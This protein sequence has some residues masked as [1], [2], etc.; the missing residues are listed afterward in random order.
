MNILYTH[1]GTPLMQ[2]GE[3]IYDF[4]G[5]NM[6]LIVG[7]LSTD[8]EV[9]ESIKERLILEI[10]NKTESFSLTTNSSARE[11]NDFISSLSELT[12]FYTAVDIV[13][14]SINN[15]N[16]LTTPKPHEKWVWNQ[17][18]SAWMTPVD[19]PEGAPEGVYIWSD[20]LINWEPAEP[21]P[22]RS[23]VWDEESHTYRPP[24]PYPLDAEEGEFVWD[25]EN[26]SWVLNV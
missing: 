11:I 4:T 1:R 19:Y 12:E 14:E 25:E 6:S 10:R 2:I 3:V 21:K 26:I 13:Q 16:M 23:W 24:V 20:D 9:C 18:I 22:H 8:I 17:E 15:H 5:P 7:E